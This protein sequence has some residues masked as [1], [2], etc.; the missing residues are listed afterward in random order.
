MVLWYF[1]EVICY[2]EEY[3]VSRVDIC[4]ERMRH[5]SQCVSTLKRVVWY[6]EDGG[7]VL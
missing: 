6:I 7:M 5:K 2:F 3:V 1:E 4:R